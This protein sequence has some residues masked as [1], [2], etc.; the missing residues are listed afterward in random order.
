MNSNGDSTSPA[1]NSTLQIFM[2]FSIKFMTSCDILYILRQSIIQLCETISYAFYMPYA[3]LLS[4][5]IIIIIYSLE[6][7]TSV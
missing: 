6:F 2:I 7:F 3:F 4:I 1:I 5:I